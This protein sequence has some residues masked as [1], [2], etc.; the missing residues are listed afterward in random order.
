MK[1]EFRSGFVIAVISLCAAVAPMLAQ[2]LDYVRSETR[3]WQPI[4][5]ASSAR[6]D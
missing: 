4:A 1:F 3:R 2:A 5:K 6:N